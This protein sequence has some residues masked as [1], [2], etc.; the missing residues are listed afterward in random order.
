MKSLLVRT[1]LLVP[2]VALLALPG[3][4]KADEHALPA[5]SET[6]GA[7][8]GVSWGIPGRWTIGADRPMRVATYVVPPAEGDEEGAECAVS[9]FGTGQGGDVEMNIE[10]W[11]NQFENPSTPERTSY[12]VAEMEVELVNVRGT[13]L[14]PGGPMMQSQGKKEGYQMLGAIVPAPE[15]MLFFKMT[16]PSATV[17]SAEDEF[18]AMVR[19]L[20][21]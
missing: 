8:A 4:K 19:S 3:C 11:V 14:A 20:Q 7:A 16:G 10:R 21:N 13:Y 18:V 2:A 5:L 6:K 15:G 1:A 12:T 9:F 17:A